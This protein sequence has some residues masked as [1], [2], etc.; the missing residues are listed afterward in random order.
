MG[1]NNIHHQIFI[2]KYLKSDTNINNKPLARYCLNNKM[3]SYRYFPYSSQK[4]MLDISVKLSSGD[5]IRM[6]CQTLFSAKNKI[7]F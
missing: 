2:E 6:K 4:I 7:S 5:I 1:D 3:T